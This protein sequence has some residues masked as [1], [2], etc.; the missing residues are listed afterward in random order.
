MKLRFTSRAREDYRT[1]PEKLQRIT[2][3]QIDHL[4][5]NLRH[6]SLHAKKYDESGDRW[7]AR[8][9]RDYRF[10]F[11]II[12]DTYLIIAITKHPK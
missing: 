3:K 6:P 8:V 9:N 12:G 4:V 1:L 5:D 7:Q 10:Y 2:D 11:H